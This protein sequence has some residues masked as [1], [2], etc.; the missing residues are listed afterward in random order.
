MKLSKDTDALRVKS[1]ELV[2]QYIIEEGIELTDVSQVGQLIH[3]II[4]KAQVKNPE[5][6][7]MIMITDG[8]VGADTLMGEPEVLSKEFLQVAGKNKSFSDV[9]VDIIR[10]ISAHQVRMNGGR[11]FGK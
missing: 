6:N 3:A 7:A 8:K 11:P 4:S 2:D 9:I 5:I 10:E 1:E